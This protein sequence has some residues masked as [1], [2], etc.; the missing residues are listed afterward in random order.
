MLNFQVKGEGKPIVFLHGFLESLS[1]W[2]YLHLEKIPGKCIL[3]DLPGHGQSDL[4]DPSEE[5]N[6]EFMVDEVLEVL[7]YLSVDSYNLVGHSMGGYIGLILKAKDKRCEKLV[8]VNSNFWSDSEQKKK[9]RI[10]IADLVF[11]AKQLFIHEAIP[12]LFGKPEYFELEIQELKKEAMK[13]LPESIAYASLAMRNRKDFSKEIQLHPYN[14]F[15]IHGKLDRLIETDYLK[16]KIDLDTNFFLI[17]NA[18]HMA[19]IEQPQKV[20][21]I[22]ELIF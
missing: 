9:D 19:H 20:V 1:M 13:M 11:K 6:L 7:S 12:N 15:F 4:M 18:G 2:S 16:S 8:L 14:Y 17:E 10:R 21:E 22:L 3:I 5:P